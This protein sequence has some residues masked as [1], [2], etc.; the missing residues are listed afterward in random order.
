[1]K[2]T[3]DHL[4]H[5]KVKQLARI[6]QILIDGV[7]VEKII[8]LDPECVSAWLNMQELQQDVLLIVTGVNGENQPEY[9]LN[10][11]IK[12]R[13]QFDT[14]VTTIVYSIDFVNTRLKEANPFFSEMIREGTLLF[15][16]GNIPLTAI[17][18][19][20]EEERAALQKKIDAEYEYW[21]ATA[22]KLLKATDQYL[23]ENDKDLALL[24]LRQ[25]VMYIYNSVIFW[26]WGTVP[27][28]SHMDALRQGCEVFSAP[29]A[30]V[31]K[32]EYGLGN[33]PVFIFS[34]GMDISYH[35]YYRFSHNLSMEELQML[36][37]KAGLLQNIARNIPRRKP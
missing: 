24:M 21:S 15:D 4:P 17:V 23:K 9:R 34:R 18:E 35:Y 22:E 27:G 5:D 8:L 11:D 12:Y 32:A 31:F 3:L 19:L 16:A 20:G 30:A 13:C 6:I 10:D 37:E 14:P 28:G 33:L 2:I 36:R 26:Y 7:A 29:L 25:A 1:M